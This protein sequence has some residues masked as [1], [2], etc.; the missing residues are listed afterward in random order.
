[1]QDLIACQM[2]CGDSPD[3]DVE[4]MSSFDFVVQR[5]TDGLPVGRLLTNIG[6][7]PKFVFVF[8]G[9][10]T[11]Y[12]D[13]EL[14]YVLSATALVLMSVSRSGKGAVPHLRAVS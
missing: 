5:E 3:Y 8:S 4:H 1:M 9:E 10:G 11:Q 6:T 7:S 12:F 2:R 13:S 14:L